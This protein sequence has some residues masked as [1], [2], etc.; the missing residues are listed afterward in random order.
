MPKRKKQRK[1]RNQISK[2]KNVFNG[3]VTIVHNYVPQ[4]EPPE[5]KSWWGGIFKFV[6]ATAKFIVGL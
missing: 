4:I 3:N 5:K 6:G 2:T 1:V